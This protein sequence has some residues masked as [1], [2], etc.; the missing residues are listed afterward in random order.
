MDMFVNPL[1]QIFFSKD[2]VFPQD[3]ETLPETCLIKKLTKKIEDFK[4]YLS[5]EEKK[6]IIYPKS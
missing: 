3:Y 5:K 6:R 1:I 4:K 2:L